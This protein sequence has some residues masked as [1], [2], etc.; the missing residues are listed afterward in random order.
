VAYPIFIWQR[1]IKPSPSSNI[2]KPLAGSCLEIHLHADYTSLV[3]YY[4]NDD[5][6]YNSSYLRWN[7]ATLLN[8]L[9]GDQR[10]YWRA[11]P[12][13]NLL[14]HPEIYGAWTSGWSF[15][16]VGFAPIKLHTSSGFATPAF[17]W[18]MAEGAS[19]YR[20][21]VS[22]DPDFGSTVIDQ[23]TPLT[24][25]TPQS[26]LLQGHYYWRVQV[27]RFGEVVNGW[28]EVKQF[29][30]ELPTPEGL[31]PD[32][33]MLNYAPTF[34]WDP[35]VK[36]NDQ[37]QPVL[38]ALKYRLQ[39]SL[40]PDFSQIYDSTDTF[41][42]CWTPTKGYQDRNYYWRVA[43][44]D[45]NNQLGQYSDPPATFT[46]RYP[47]GRLLSPGRGPLESTPTFIWAPVDGAATYVFE[48]SKYPNFSV[49][50]DLAV[51]VNTRFTPMKSYASGAMYYW[52]VAM[53]DGDGIQGPF[54][55]SSII[56]GDIYPSFLPVIQRFTTIH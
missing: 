19:T 56:I 18:D 50:Y 23:Q 22:T 55:S 41:N 16:R 52:R 45:G 12:R 5:D 17:S 53:R 43:M 10:Y 6:A 14:G 38:T 42:N 20:L 9:A 37:G 35:L 49:P 4:L 30:D 44:I 34:C 26:T 51:T 11:Q 39:V 46:K 31:T 54:T 33:D 25:Y 28:S 48:V 3:A 32:G 24:S 15:Q 8:D 13:Y 29:D 47:T 7:N 2:S 1:V 27:N 40:E 21:L 36:Y